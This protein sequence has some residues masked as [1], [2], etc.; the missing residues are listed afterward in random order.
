[1]SSAYF[2]FTPWVFEQDE[3][4]LHETYFQTCIIVAACISVMECFSNVTQ[5]EKVLT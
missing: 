5:S 2:V 1:M 4:A 3:F